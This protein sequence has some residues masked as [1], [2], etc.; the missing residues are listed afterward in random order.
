[1][2]LLRIQKL[3][4]IKLTE[5][6]ES[7]P[8][9]GNK[10]IDNK[11]L[12]MMLRHQAT[13]F[14]PDHNSKKDTTQLPATLRKQAGESIDESH[15]LDFIM[16]EIISDY[17]SADAFTKEDMLNY[18]EQ[19]KDPESVTLDPEDAE[20]ETRATKQIL[21]DYFNYDADTGKDGYTP[22]EMRPELK[23]K[24]IRDMEES[25]PPGMEDMV[26]KLKR[27]YPGHPEK[28]FSTA[29]SIYDK[30]HNKKDESMDY[31][32][33]EAYVD[34][35]NQD[36]PEDARHACAMENNMYQ[37]E[38]EEECPKLR[39]ATDL[40]TSLVMHSYVPP[41]D[42][43][44]RVMVV[45]ADEGNSDL[46]PEFDKWLE[47]YG[48]AEKQEAEQDMSTSYNNEYDESDNN[49]DFTNDKMDGDLDFTDLD[50]IDDK[51]NGDLD[52]TDEEEFDEAFNLNNGYDDINDANGQD[53]FP[54]GADSPVVR[55]IGGNSKQGDNPEQKRV[56]VAEVHKE[57]V[58]SYRKYLGE[59]SKK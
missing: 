46:I 36:N 10:K 1:M 43:Y 31:D 3:A 29:W 28:A 50:F 11:D 49:L 27:E 44:D 18:L 22:D 6:V 23:N 21:K 34:V 13:P 35:C 5:G 59:N 8:T 32:V 56:A 7:I 58:Y 38:N 57:L 48:H 20:L 37:M 52:F 26:K 9:I 19:L 55:D 47:D 14:L 41:E 4:G 54:T 25:A 16:K 17:K 2:D 24:R 12:P 51:E 53:Y 40:F 33:D 39:Q 15:S 30:K 42:A 45:L